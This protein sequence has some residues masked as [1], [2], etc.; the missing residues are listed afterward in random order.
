LNNA[1]RVLGVVAT[2]TSVVEG[3]KEGRTGSRKR[4]IERRGGRE[5]RKEEGRKVR[6]YRGR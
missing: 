5:Q 2:D 3:E 4:G 1:C 6:R